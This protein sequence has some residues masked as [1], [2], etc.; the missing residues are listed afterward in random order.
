[1]GGCGG[2]LYTG[3]VLS[4]AL[5][6]FNRVRLNLPGSALTPPPFVTVTV[7]IRRDLRQAG[8]AAGKHVSDGRANRQASE[9]AGPRGRPPRTS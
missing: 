9:R 3:E 5:N 2:T 1:M 8:R 7:E 4:D 6:K